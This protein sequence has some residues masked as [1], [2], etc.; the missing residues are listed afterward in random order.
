MLATDT[1]RFIYLHNLVGNV[2]SGVNKK[3]LYQASSMSKLAPTELA[4]CCKSKDDFEEYAY[5]VSETSLKQK[6]HPLALKPYYNMR[7]ISRLISSLSSKDVIYLRYPPTPKITVPIIINRGPRIIYEINAI[8]SNEGGENASVSDGWRTLEKNLGPLLLS[9]ADG[10]I[11][12]TNEIL[13]YYTGKNK[14][15]RITYGVISNGIKSN[16]FPVRSHAQ[17]HNGQINMIGVALVSNW[18]GFDRVIE[19]ISNYKGNNEF[20]FH[21]VGNGPEVDTLKN[22]ANRQKVTNNV[23]FHGFKSGE[24][25]NELFNRCEIAVSTLALH[26]KGLSEHCSLKSREYCA[27]GIPFIYAGTDPDFKECFPYAL[28][29]PVGEDEVDMA[30]VEKF[31]SQLADATPYLNNMEEYAKKRLDWDIKM[32]ELKSFIDQKGFKNSIDCH[33]Q[34]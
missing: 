34:P 30:L 14:N 23:I 4:V 16:G 29:I 8:L 28:K 18:H 3:I 7:D 33:L 11:C 15:Q 17:A 1:Y 25:L 31:C 12:V 13:N 26:R 24:S 2:Y 10:G 27:R 6:L 21:I 32:R 19:G 22:L 5:F 20:I 9:R